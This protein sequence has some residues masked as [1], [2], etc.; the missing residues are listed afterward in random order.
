[1]YKTLG[2]ILH[3]VITDDINTWLPPRDLIIISGGASGVDS[4]AIDWAIVNW[5]TFEEYKADWKTYGKSAGMIRNK[6]MLDSG[7]D[8]VIA[9]PGGKGTTNMVNIAKKAGVSVKE[10]LYK[11]GSCGV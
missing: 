11:G 1:M 9:F 10:I 5:V 6:Q 2:E 7:I 3:P 4:I 8:L